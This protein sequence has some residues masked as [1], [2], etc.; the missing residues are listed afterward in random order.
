MRTICWIA[1]ALGLVVAG[2][3]AAQ[4]VRITTPEKGILVYPRDGQLAQ[5][6]ADILELNADRVRVKR[7][8]FT[9][10]DTLPWSRLKLVRTASA[11]YSFNAAKKAVVKA[12]AGSE[13]RI[14]GPIQATVTLTT[15]KTATGVLTSMVPGEIGFAPQGAAFAFTYPAKD[16]RYVKVDGRE[17]VGNPL[18]GV[19]EVFV[20]KDETTKVITN[21][22]GKDHTTK[23]V[24]PGTGSGGNLSS[25]GSQTGYSSTTTPSTNPNTP[26]PPAGDTPWGWICCGGFF[27]LMVLAGIGGRRKIGEIWV[28]RADVYE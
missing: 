10:P 19:F 20:P 22:T 17:Y 15:D 2:R 27:V 18:T 25:T 5:E 7:T 12:E 3:A 21:E 1:L 11:D 23:L 9:V 26:P 13:L 4:D 8:G 6:V 16:V 24:G 14:I 28:K